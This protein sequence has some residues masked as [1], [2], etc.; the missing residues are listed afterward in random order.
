MTAFATVEQLGNLLGRDFPAEEVSHVEY[1]LESAS[2]HLRSVIGQL[3]FPETVSTYTGYPDAGREDLPQWPVVSVDTVTRNGAPIPFRYRP[4]YITVAGSAPIEV[5]FTWG[6]KEAPK[7][8]SR[9]ACVLAGQALTTLELGL[10][11]TAGGLSSIALD[12]FKA[13]FADGGAATGMVLT[14]HAEAG[15]RSQFGRGGM[16]VLETNG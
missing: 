14:P 5:T 16:T 15:I 4:G 11:V 3:V 7:E 6:L 8:L 9:L 13:A 12:E 1:L 10:G 2:S